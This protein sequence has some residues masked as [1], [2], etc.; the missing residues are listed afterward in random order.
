MRIREPE[1]E[2]SPP[3]G[4]RNRV[5]LHRDRMGRMGFMGRA[6]SRPVFIQRCPVCVPTLNTLLSKS[7]PGERRR[8]NVFATED[9]SAVQGEVET[10]SVTIMNREILLDP[11]CFFQS[12]LAVLPRMIRYLLED[13]SGNTVLD[14]Y[15]G[16]GLFG[17][18]LRDAYKRVI[19]VDNE[20]AALRLAR[21]NVS[22]GDHRF[23]RTNLNKQVFP[24]GNWK[25][26]DTVVADPPRS[27]LSGA[28]RSFIVRERPRHFIYVSCDPVTLARD[29][30][31][32][33][34]EGYK[35]ESMRLFDFYPQTSHVEAVARLV[36]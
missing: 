6:S 3:F 27:G 29:A 9:W 17:S 26:I 25:G 33:C 10:A 32:L 11:A 24:A 4:Y 7:M 5:Q 1:I 30:G 28:V 23:L 22:G 35:I 14:L 18:F 15:C 21:R 36:L 34:S 8:F 16:V 2:P 12:N 20:S 13:L 31:Y 19:G